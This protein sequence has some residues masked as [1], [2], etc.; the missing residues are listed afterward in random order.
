MIL[1]WFV[2]ALASAAEGLAERLEES[3]EE[4]R[5]EVR[6]RSPY[7]AERS[8]LRGAMGLLVGGG[9]TCDD[10]TL[11]EAQALLT[12]ADFRLELIQDGDD[13]VALIREAREIRGAGLY[14]V[15]CGTARPVVWQAPHSFHDHDT[16]EIVL[17]L[18]LESGARAVMWNT[19]HRYKSS[20]KE[21]RADPIHPADVTREYGSLFQA[22]TVGMAGG[23][24]S[25]RFVQVHGFARETA[26]W[27]VIVSTGSDRDP[28]TGLAAALDPL[29]GGAAAFGED[30]DTLEGGENVQGHLLNETGSIRFIHVELSPEARR[31]LERDADLRA[32]FV[33]AV[34]DSEW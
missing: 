16:G 7:A 17:A 25:L 5:T 11:G 3:L 24:P 14:A 21:R 29:L 2:L 9:A 22:A 19:V 32:R 28:P 6:W 34:A 30:T 20:P 12:A 8:A 10:E 4:V 26:S 27:E 15:R 18:F 1:W 23:D 33:Q 13:R 31:R